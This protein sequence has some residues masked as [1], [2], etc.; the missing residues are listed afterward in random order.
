MTKDIEVALSQCKAESKTRQ[1]ISIEPRKIN[2]LVKGITRGE[3]EVYLEGGEKKTE[4]FLSHK[5][6]SKPNGGFA[7][8]LDL[9]T[10][11]QGDIKV[12]PPF[13]ETSVPGV[14]SGGDAAAPMKAVVLALAHGASMA[15]GLAAQIE[16]ED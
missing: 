10:T 6:K 13:N 11:L 7:T 16:A 14:F 15:A 5:P 4:G 3:V 8:Q 1:N 9:E 12:V 2:R